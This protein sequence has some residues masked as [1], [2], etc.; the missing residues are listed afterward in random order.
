MR[1][2]TI[3]AHWN[4][5][6]S[7]DPIEAGVA[8]DLARN[9]GPITPVIQRLHPALVQPVSLS[10]SEFANLLAFLRDGLLDERA[11][12]ENLVDSIPKSVPSGLSLHVFETTP[13]GP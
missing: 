7:Y 13:S 8:R 10:E 6:Q 3:F 12:P 9:T 2:A 4:W 1:F 11:R 5:L